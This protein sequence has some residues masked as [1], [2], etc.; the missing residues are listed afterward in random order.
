VTTRGERRAHLAFAA[1]L[2]RVSHPTREVRASFTDET[3]RVYQAYAPHIAEPAIRAGTFV[4]PFKRARMTWIKPS[5][6]WMMYRSGW[7]TKPDQERVLGIDILREGF[8]WALAHACVTPFTS[9]LHA[10]EERWKAALAD[11]PVRVQWDPERDVKLEPLPWRAIQ[12]GIGGLAVERY[13]DTWIKRIEDVTPLARDVEAR[14][15][16]GD[17]ETARA[18]LPREETYPVSEEIAARLDC[19]RR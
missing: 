17:L 1:I 5:F 10:S 8:E 19:S 2:R 12:I 16:G 13:V 14:V 15:R 6:T 3:V 4:S 18:L 11:S 9:T 7:G